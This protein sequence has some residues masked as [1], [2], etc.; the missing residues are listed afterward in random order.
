[1]LP[2]EKTDIK[3]ESRFLLLGAPFTALF[4]I[5]TARDGLTAHDLLDSVGGAAIIVV[6][7]RL[8]LPLW[9]KHSKFF[10]NIFSALIMACVWIAAA[11][12]VGNFEVG[13]VW[14][15]LSFGL[16]YLLVSLIFDFARS[17]IK[18]IQNSRPIS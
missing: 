2:G 12:Y 14:Q 17:Y 18:R 13:E 6:A 3:G 16:S 11:A 4:L 10:L 8:T 1:M 15:G 7:A 5:I 9:I